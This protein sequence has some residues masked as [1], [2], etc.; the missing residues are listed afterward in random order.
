MGRAEL[1]GN[2]KRHLVPTYQPLGTG[3][4]PEGARTPRAARGAGSGKTLCHSTHWPAEDPA[5][6]CCGAAQAIPQT[7]AVIVAARH[8]ALLAI[9][10][11]R[12]DN[13]VRWAYFFSP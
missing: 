7:R 9:R 1:I 4:R 6:A 13:A 11:T 10:T 3:D 2:G 5:R 12:F 8:A